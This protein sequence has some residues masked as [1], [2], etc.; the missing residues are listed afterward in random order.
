MKGGSLFDLLIS[1]GKHLEEEEVIH[2]MEQILLSADLL[3]SNNIVHRDIKLENILVVEKY[4][5]DDLLNLQVKLCDLGVAKQLET[6][7]EKGLICGTPGYI[8]PEILNSK[9][10]GTKADI[11]SIGATM[12]SL[13]KY[14]NLIYDEDEDEMLSKN[15]AFQVEELEN[16]IAHF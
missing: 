3:H 8:A 14:S 2:V 6:P 11:F 10:F 5:D 4:T 16:R 15:K 9:H 12:F 7:E 13:L 1:R